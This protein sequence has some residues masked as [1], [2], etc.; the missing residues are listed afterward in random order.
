MKIIHISM[1]EYEKE[2]NE[3]VVLEARL[4]DDIRRKYP[5]QN[6][7]WKKNNIQYIN[8]QE[9]HG[10]LL[11]STFLSGGSLHMPF[12]MYKNSIQDKAVDIDAGRILTDAE[13]AHNCEGIRLFF[14]IDYRTSTQPLPT[15]DTAMMHLRVVLRVVKECFPS[16]DT[17]MHVAT[18]SKK[19]KQKRSSSIIELAWGI[20]V[21]FPF[22]VTT[23]ATMKLIAQLLDTRMSNLFTTWS[24]I[25]D[26]ASYRTSNATLRP[27]Y[28][29]KMIECPICVSDQKQ[30]TTVDNKRRRSDVEMDIDSL[31]RLQLSST[32]DCF[33]G[34]KVDPSVYRYIGSMTSPEE[35]RLS[36]LFQSTCEVLM[37]MSIVPTQMGDFTQ[38]FL[39]PNDMGDDRD[40]IPIADILFPVE[41]RT[42]CA[43]HR[44]KNLIRVPMSIYPAGYSALLNIMTRMHEEYRHI[45]IHYVSM[46]T[47]KKT[48]LINVKGKGSRYCPYKGVHHH[49]NRIY[50]TLNLLRA[51]IHVHCFDPECKKHKDF[52]DL[53]VRSMSL[54]DKYNVTR[55]FG[56]PDTSNRPTISPIVHEMTKPLAVVIPPTEVVVTVDEKKRLWEEK[57]RLYQLS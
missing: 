33:S 29:F 48:F 17:T 52:P 20:H 54:V 24:D 11:R 45:A 43:Q 3:V 10:D 2:Y 1:S 41:R 6:S 55:G 4:A 42:V 32:C 46:D 34:R 27:C 14:E 47:Q 26:P 25:I 15:M 16:A 5:F 50:F 12:A 9:T 30:T 18:C 39:R 38:G 28:S 23:T 8:N 7:V 22:I 35:E 40:M 49:S 56:L 44:R 37:G 57:R 31:F 36:L 13:I 21:V 53:L 19:R 51:R